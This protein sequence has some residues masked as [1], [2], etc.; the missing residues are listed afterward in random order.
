MINARKE[1]VLAGVGIFSGLTDQELGRLADAFDD[2][3]VAA[4][5]FLREEGGRGHTL[6]VIATGGA[7]VYLPKT[8]GSSERFEEIELARIGPGDVYGEYSFIDMRDASASVCTLV[9][10]RILQIE[11]VAL[12]KLLDEYARIA[13]RIYENLLIMHIDRLR[14]D[15]RSLDLFTNTWA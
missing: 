6:G 3:Q 10:S 11:H 5:T 13:R 8:G 15:N 2:V 7:R 4:G 9:D 14:N 1:D 12:H